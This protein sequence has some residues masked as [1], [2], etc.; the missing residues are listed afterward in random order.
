MATKAYCKKRSLE[1][2]DAYLMREPEETYACVCIRF[3]RGSEEPWQI[4]RFVWKAEEDQTYP[5]A[6]FRRD[7]TDSIAAHLTHDQKV[8]N[9]GVCMYFETD[10]G[11][12]WQHKHVGWSKPSDEPSGKLESMC[13]ADIDIDTPFDCRRC[14]EDGHFDGD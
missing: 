4:E 11:R 12:L 2:I 9:F 3:R 10:G 6:Q 7:V 8:T 1:I 5:K 14:M 13:G